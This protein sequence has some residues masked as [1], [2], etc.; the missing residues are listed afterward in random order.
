MMINK[1]AKIHVAE[2]ASASEIRK[3]LKISDA[4][5]KAAKFIVLKSLKALTKKVSDG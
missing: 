3:T 5:Q 2:K 1:V 4:S